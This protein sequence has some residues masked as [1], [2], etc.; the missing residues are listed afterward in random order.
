MGDVVLVYLIIMKKVDEEEGDNKHEIWIVQVQ[1]RDDDEVH[2]GD[3]NAN[4]EQNDIPSISLPSI[5]V[6]GKS[7]EKYSGR[8]IKDTRW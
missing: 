6:D 1:H 5:I 7:E 2:N 8:Q 4:E 3:G